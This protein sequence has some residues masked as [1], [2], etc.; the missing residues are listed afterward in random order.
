MDVISCVVFR[1]VTENNFGGGLEIGGTSL[2]FGAKVGDATLLDSDELLHG[3]R[4]YQGDPNE[5]LVGVFSIQKS[6]LRLKGVK[7]QRK[8][9]VNFNE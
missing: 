5:R 8:K 4:E 3:S 7:F 9:S 1:I 6:Y 2:C